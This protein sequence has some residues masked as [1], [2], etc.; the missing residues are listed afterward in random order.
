MLWLRGLVFTLLVPAVV[1]L[2]VP[3]TLYAGRHP[4]PGAWQAGWLLVILGAA[5]YLVCLIQFLA[6]GGTPAIF[7]ARH[8]R[9]LIGEEPTALVGQGIYRISRNPMYLGVLTAVFGQAALFRSLPV[10]VYGLFLF[11][12]FHLV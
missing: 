12:F 2:Y 9:L 10:A 4:Q 1:G 7:F 6:A 8:L 11:L 5:T 3:S